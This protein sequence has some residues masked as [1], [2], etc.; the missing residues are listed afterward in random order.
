MFG[1]HPVHKVARDATGYNPL[2]LA[3]VIV[4]GYEDPALEGENITFLC[5]IGS[6]HS[7]P[8]LSTCMGMENGNQTP[9]R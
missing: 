2:S 6:I 3:N 8:N 5:P 9:W 4:E 1:M 7:G